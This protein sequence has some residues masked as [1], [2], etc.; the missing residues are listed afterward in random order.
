MSF[1]SLSTT[2]GNLWVLITNAT[3]KNPSVLSRIAATGV[4][5]ERLPD[6]LLRRRSPC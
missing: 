2:F 5:P 4:E 1:W 6:V 3:V